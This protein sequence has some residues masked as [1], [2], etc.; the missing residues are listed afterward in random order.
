MATP[1]PKPR[2]TIKCCDSYDE[3]SDI[4]S[5]IQSYSS[6]HFQPAK[7]LKIRLSLMIVCCT[8][9]SWTVLDS[10]ISDRTALYFVY[11]SHWVLLVTT[12]LYLICSYV[13]TLVIHERLS[14]TIYTPSK[15]MD[16]IHLEQQSESIPSLTELGLFGWNRFVVML[17]NVSLSSSIVFALMF[18]TVIFPKTGDHHVESLYPLKTQRILC[19]IY[20]YRKIAE[21]TT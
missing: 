6:I 21:H 16:D 5:T 10:I 4:A 11:A 15:T 20:F 3:V 7:W 12:T 13:V 8:I 14:S 2:R 19:S 18:W 17:H 9:F 1:P